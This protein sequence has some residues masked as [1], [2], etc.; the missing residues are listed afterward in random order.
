MLAGALL[1]RNSGSRSVR[2]HAPAAGVTTLSSLICKIIRTYFLIS[3]FCLVN[4]VAGKAK[5]LRN[6]NKN[7]GILWLQGIS[8]KI[9]KHL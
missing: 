6:S 2:L 4:F 1:P 7:T 8:C 3:L 9:F 5:L